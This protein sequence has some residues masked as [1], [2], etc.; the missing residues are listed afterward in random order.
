MGAKTVDQEIV[1][2]SKGTLRG[3]QR[4]ERVNA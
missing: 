3:Q 2:K 4:R 1:G